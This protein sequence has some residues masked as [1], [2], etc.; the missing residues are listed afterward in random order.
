MRLPQCSQAF[1]R[2]RKRL[3]VAAG[4]ESCR[5]V[6]LGSEYAICMTCNMLSSSCPFANCSFC[7]VACR[8]AAQA[9]CSGRIR[10]NVSPSQGDLRLT[11]DPFEVS[12]LAGTC[13][14]ALVSDTHRKLVKVEFRDRRGTLRVFRFNLTVHD[15]RNT[16]ERRD[17]I[18]PGAQQFFGACFT[19]GSD[20]PGRRS[21]LEG[22]VQISWQSQHFGAHTSLIS[23]RSTLEHDLQDL[24]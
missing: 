23:W 9:Q 19:A 8:F 5:A 2:V 22:H 13:S 11:G 18:L 10:G 7:E 16:F 3:S 24:R 6:G 4:G 17:Q 14:P 15:R 12:C 1:A 21:C 20:L